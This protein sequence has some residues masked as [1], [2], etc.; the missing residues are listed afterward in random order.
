MF[1]QNTYIKRREKLISRMSDGLVLMLGNLEAPRNYLHNTYGFRQ[2][3]SYLYFFGI[4]KP[5]FAGV[6]D[7]DAAETTIYADDYSMDDIIWVGSQKSVKEQA[8]EVGVSK[9]GTRADLATAIKEAQAKGRKIHFLPPYRGDNCLILQDLVGIPAGKLKSEQSFELVMNVIALRNIKEDVE[10]IEIEKACDIGYLMHTTAMMRA[11]AGVSEQQIAGEIEGIAISKG[12]A[13]SF[14]SILSQNGQT[15]HN[16]DHSGILEQGRLMLVDAGGETQSRYAS[17]NTRTTPVG[18]VF[19]AKQKEI[20]SIVHDALE[21]TIALTEPGVAYLDLHLKA[22]GVITEGLKSL[23]LMK[24]DTEEAVISG[25]H[26]L[27]MPHGLGHMMGLD[28]HDMEDLDQTLVGYDDEIRPVD[29]FGTRN[30]RLGKKLEVGNVITNEPGLYF[31]PALIEK[32]KR[33]GT[34]SEFINFDKLESYYEFGGIRLE[35]DILVT[36]DGYRGL[37]S[38]RIPVSI[39]EVEELCRKS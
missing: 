24:G 27:F 36:E 5:D 18:G 9:T 1:S 32:W 37:G 26:A 25:A 28:V 16:H 11:K 4:D 17:D 8:E 10:I 20:Y 39:E 7:I 35:D 23:G 31:I 33:E 19:S 38:K 12:G 34:N 15:L 21:T 6:I 14:P 30:L 22:A 13:T 2:D 3:S 29:Q